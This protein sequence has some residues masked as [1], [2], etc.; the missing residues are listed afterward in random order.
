[1]ELFRQPQYGWI[2]FIELFR[3]KSLFKFIEECG[4]MS[5]S[6][7]KV[8]QFQGFLGIVGII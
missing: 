6:L 7:A 1:M 2:V 5:R 8:C 4:L 3:Q